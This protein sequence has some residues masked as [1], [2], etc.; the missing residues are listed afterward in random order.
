MSLKVLA[1]DTWRHSSVKGM[2]IQ[3]RILKSFLVCLITLHGLSEAADEWLTLQNNSGQSIRVKLLRMQGNAVH[4]EMAG[5]RR[6]KTSLSV[7]NEASQS[8][9]RQHFYQRLLVPES[10]EC[11]LSEV[12]LPGKNKRLNSQGSREIT[13]TKR[14]YSIVL[15]S[16]IAEPVHDIRLEYLIF[17]FEDV[18]GAEKRSEGRVNRVK[19]KLEL[20]TLEAYAKQKLQTESIDFTETRLLPGWVFSKG[21]GARDSKDRLD[22]IWI[23]LF[24]GDQLVLQQSRPASLSTNETW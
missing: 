17:H 19:G 8:R 20:A 10:F 6:M 9:I 2:L 23:K 21:S 7:Y 16:R 1:L 12:R 5:G 14:A 13:E 11:K 18:L 3:S 24:V 4:I 22:G 15:S